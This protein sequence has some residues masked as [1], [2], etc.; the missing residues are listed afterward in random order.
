M[1]ICIELVRGPVY[2]TGEDVECWVKISNTLG[3]HNTLFF[4]IINVDDTVLFSRKYKYYRVG[5]G[6]SKRTIY[7]P[8]NP[9]AV[10]VWAERCG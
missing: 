3:N 5:K 1:E 10:L 8:P 2:L 9:G 7:D 4:I 6:L